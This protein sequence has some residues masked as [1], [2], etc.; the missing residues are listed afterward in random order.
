MGFNKQRRMFL[1]LQ[2]G[3]VQELTRYISAAMEGHQAQD[4]GS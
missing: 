1:S 3:F 4:H 2:L